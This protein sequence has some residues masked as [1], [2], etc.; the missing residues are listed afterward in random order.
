MKI[1]VDIGHPG[2]VHYFKNA[3]EIL[4]N[5][6]HEIFIIARDR[7]FIFE[8]LKKYNL[9]FV[10]RGKGSNTLFGKFWYMLKAD[11]KI[12][13][14]ARKINPDLFLSFSSPYL[15]QVSNLMRKPHITMNDSEH[16]DNMHSKFTYPFSSV[17]LTPLSYQA[18]LGRK[19]VRFDNVVEGLYINSS[20]FNPDKNIKKELG[21]KNNEEYVILRFVS[22]NAHHDIGQSGID[23]NTKIKLIELLKTKYR[24]YISSE[25]TLPKEFKKYKIN[26]SPEKMH[27]A[28]AFSTMFIGESYTMASESALLGTK[29]I[30]INS[31]PLACNI[32]VE[33]EA[34]VAKYF[35]SSKDVLSYIDKLMKNN[36]LKEITQEKS[37]LMQ[38]NFIDATQFLVWFIEEYPNS[39]N[40]MKEDPKVQ[41]KFKY[42][43]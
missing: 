32:K 17:I 23:I 8:L 5:K 29:A 1:L 37:K 22:W 13:K 27:D 43:Q 15:G 38:K 2:H 25:G 31:L 41:Y 9:P 26:I 28:L 21:V 4:K 36:R 34:G 33:E 10:S 20:Y 12:W 18:N 40:I 24:V 30:V 14:I 35:I 11:L 6:G 19:Q 42:K 3:M 39:F 16:T 7:E